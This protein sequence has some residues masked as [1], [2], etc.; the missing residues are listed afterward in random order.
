[1]HKKP[2]PKQE[3]G[4]AV[5]AICGPEA[6]LRDQAL[7]QILH[8]V[9]G[10]APDPLARSD[11]DSDSPLAEVFDDLRTLP[12]LVS[13]RAVVIHDADGF[14]KD[15]RDPLEE[16]CREPSPSAILILLCAAFDKRT[17]L[18]KLIGEQNGLRSCETIRGQALTG[19]IVRRAHEAHAKTIERPGA[20]RLQRLIGDDLQA[21]DSELFKLAIYVGERST[22]RRDDV[23]CLVGLRREER[24]FAIADAMIRGDA[25]SALALWDQVWAT[26]RAAPAR[27][28]GG[29]AWVL[30]R[31]LEA[32]HHQEAGRSLSGVA[33]QFWTS[34]PELATRL[35]RRPMRDFEDHLCALQVAEAGVK[36]GVHDPRSAVEKLIVSRSV[37]TTQ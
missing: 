15:H 23:D 36:S 19:W 13:R 26:D 33:Q 1:M 10:A 9:I 30:R 31:Y 2:L 29:L 21:L 32:K 3:S 37:V 8:E 4:T 7:R 28:I 27:A 12:M 16:Y 34:E 5:Y 6:F 35:A 22:I 14:I 25:A 20:Q 24:V 11:F 18:Y 17:R